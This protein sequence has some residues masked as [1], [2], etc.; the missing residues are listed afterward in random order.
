[1]LSL[2][3]YKTANIAI[4]TGISLNFRYKIKEREQDM[5]QIGITKRDK[6]KTARK[7]CTRVK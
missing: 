5:Q 1:M 6:I 4:L 2:A 7:F 3:M